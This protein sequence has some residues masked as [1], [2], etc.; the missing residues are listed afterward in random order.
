[1]R[2]CYRAAVTLAESL[3][4][5]PHWLDCL[6]DEAPQLRPMNMNI[7]TDGVILT[8]GPHPQT[9][10]LAGGADL[11]ALVLSHGH[12]DH[13]GLAGFIAVL[14][15]D[16]AD[17]VYLGAA[18][19]L[20]FRAISAWSEAC[21]SRSVRGQQFTLMAPDARLPELAHV[22]VNAGQHEGV[23]DADNVKQGAV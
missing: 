9:K 4:R 5:A 19:G 2:C 22:G 10:G 23:P 14:V 8:S 20:S 15:P 7:L 1:M 11:L 3:C 12:V 16:Q 17:D 6:A 18:G 13:W 21:R